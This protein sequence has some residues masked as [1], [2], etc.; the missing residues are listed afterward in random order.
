MTFTLT[1]EFKL[2][3]TAHQKE[4]FQQWLETNRQVYNYA[5][6]ERKDWYKSRACALNSCSIKGQYIIPA[7][8]P[9]PTF[10]IQCKALTQAKKQYPHIKR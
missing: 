5:L 1:Y 10:A 9:R 3:P 6:G 4:I 8:T 2:K 7:D